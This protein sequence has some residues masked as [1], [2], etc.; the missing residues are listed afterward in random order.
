MKGLTNIVAVA[1][2]VFIICV[3]LLGGILFMLDK[4]KDKLTYGVE[5]LQKIHAYLGNNEI[6]YSLI[7]IRND[8]R[9][10]IKENPKPEYEPVEASAYVIEPCPKCGDI[11]TIGI[12]QDTEMYCIR[13]KNGTK[14]IYESR[15]DCDLCVFGEDKIITIKTWND[16]ALARRYNNETSA[17]D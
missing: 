17:C 9:N 2:I 12:H 16:L 1:C 13:C 10:Y 3:V 14:N 15:C 8:I 7:D 4:L 6:Y 11:P 5:W